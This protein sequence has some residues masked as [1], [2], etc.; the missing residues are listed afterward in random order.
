[1]NNGANTLQVFDVSTPSAPV[2]V[3]SVGTGGGPF[4][5]AV[6]GRYA[7]VMN[8]SAS[9]LQVFDVSTPSTPVSVGSV[10]TGSG[11]ISIVVSGRYA[12][13]V[14]LN[15][16]TLQVFDLGGEYVQQ[17][18][19]G[20]METGTLQTRDT[21]TV[22]ND[23]D[24]RGGLTVSASARISGGLGV[25]N[26]TISGNGGGLTNLNAAQ[27]SGG[28]PA[29]VSLPAANLTGALPAISGASLTSLPA[30]NLTGALPAISGASLTSL[31][32]SAIASGTIPLARLPALNLVN[33]SG[34]LPASTSYTVQGDT[35]GGINS[36]VALVVNNDTNSGDAPA[37][38]LIGNG[39]E[40][41]G[42][43]SVSSQ[44][45]QRTGLIAQFGNSNAFVVSITNDGTIYCKATVL[46]S[47]RNVKENFQAL[48]ARSVLDKLAAMPVTEWNYKDDPTD[49]K[50]IGPV[51]QD[52]QAAFGLNGADDK[53]ISTVDEG[54]VAL[55]AIQGLNQKLNE[56][57]ARIHE[58][59]DEIAELKSRLEKLEQLMTENKGGAK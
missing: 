26:G 43:L 12:Y 34:A 23:L 24:V 10:S 27:L 15:A 1:V 57:D 55:A 32:G 44:N 19:A 14:N 35:T 17:L 38:R 48:D 37:L 5:V 53:H 11:A 6:A 41:S 45:F 49:K 8:E 21:V 52:F 30:G 46:S 39:G 25:E 3:G 9:T 18:E 20:T 56:K 51:A 16:S 42:V 22:G 2:S 4:S 58:Q 50:H 7:Y 54:G 33:I 29:G 31:N 36:A 59:G 13:G 47:D 28:V 40:N